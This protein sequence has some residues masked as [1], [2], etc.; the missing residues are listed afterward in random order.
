[1][2]S[3]LTICE[4][5]RQLYRRL[6]GRVS[7]STM[8]LLKMAFDMGKKIDNKL[9]QYKAKYDEGWWGENRL[10]GGTIEGQ[11]DRPTVGYVDGEG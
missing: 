9:R 4:V 8:D 5:H 1:M 2:G 11:D 10:A 3:K 6:N 7:Q